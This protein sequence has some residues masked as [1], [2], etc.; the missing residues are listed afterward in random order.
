M[1]LIIENSKLK[2][3]VDPERG[4]AICWLGRG[5]SP[6]N[7]LNAYD[8]GR[9]IQQSYYVSSLVHFKAIPCARSKHAARTSGNYC[10]DIPYFFLASAQEPPA[11]AGSSTC[12]IPPSL[13]PCC[14]FLP[15]TRVSTH[16]A[17]PR[18][19]MMAATGMGSRGGGTQ[20]RV[21]AGK[22]S[23]DRFLNAGRPQASSCS[24]APIPGTGR[25]RSFWRTW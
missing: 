11:V 15:H 17:L 6:E 23:L 3:G 12:S 5:G 10:P 25:V 20:C 4:G 14:L 1:P 21:A 22:T 7:M 24:H 19:L 16:H 8:C 13:L 18:V 2:I 9:F